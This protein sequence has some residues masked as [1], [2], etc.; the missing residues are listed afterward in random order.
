MYCKC[1]GFNFQITQMQIRS[2]VYQYPMNIKTS[3]YCLRSVLELQARKPFANDNHSSGIQ[4]VN[5]YLWDPGINFRGKITPQKKLMGFGTAE[6]SFR[7]FRQFRCLLHSIQ[8]YKTPHIHHLKS[9]E[10]LSYA[11]SSNQ[12]ISQSI[13][14]AVQVNGECCQ[15][16]LLSEINTSIKTKARSR[17]LE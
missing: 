10:T 7:V 5:F 11:A 15:L 12:Q 8:M 4:Q 17:L 16:L 14:L 1:F 2:S 13:A 6:H 9:T 3:N